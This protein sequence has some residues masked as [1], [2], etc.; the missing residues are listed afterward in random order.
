MRSAF[1][2]TGSARCSPGFGD[3]QGGRQHRR[4]RRQ[5]R[6]AGADRRCAA[7]EGRAARRE[8]R[9]QASAPEGTV[10]DG[11]GHGA[12]A[13]GAPAV[14]VKV[15]FV[16]AGRMGAPMVRRLVD[17]GHEVRALGRTEEKRTAV[18]ELGAHA[19][20]RHR[21][22]RRTRRRRRG[23]RVHRRTGRA[24]LPRRRSASRDAAGA[25]LVLHTTGSPTHRRGDRR[26]LRRTSTSSTRRSA[27]ART[28]SPRSGHAVRRRC[29]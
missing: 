3:Q 22:G 15:G 14:T 21:G 20:R 19:G 11:G 26:A 16:G 27:A 29:R 2:G 24:A 17:A 7:A 13:H 25:V 9:G 28:T 8:P 10:F 6:S 23:L 5:P 4:F 12:D 18:D 1:R